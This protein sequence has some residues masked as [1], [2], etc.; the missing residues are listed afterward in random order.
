ML[1]CSVILYK[2]YRD[3][4]FSIYLRTN[5]LC[6]VT[7]IRKQNQPEATYNKLIMIFWHAVVQR[8]YQHVIFFMMQATDSNSII[9]KPKRSRLF[10]LHY[11]EFLSFMVFAGVSKL[12]SNAQCPFAVVTQLL[13]LIPISCYSF[14]TF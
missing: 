12:C 7:G 11:I 5:L 4:K 1:E 2:C 6:K 10:I 13:I 9:F 8:Y 14:S 3:T